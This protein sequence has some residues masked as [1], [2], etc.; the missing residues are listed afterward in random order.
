[1]IFLKHFDPSRQSLLG[2]GKTY[3]L[4]TSKVGDL[5]HCINVRMKWPTGTPLKLYEVCPD[6]VCLMIKVTDDLVRKSNLARLI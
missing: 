5:A 4:Q 6:Y 2:V 1:M 3:V